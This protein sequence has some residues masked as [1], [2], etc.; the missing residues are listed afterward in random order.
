MQPKFQFPAPV[1]LNYDEFKLLRNLIF[2]LSGINLADHKK[3]LV[4]ARLFKRLRILGL[5]SFREYYEY[6]TVRDHEGLEQFELVNAISTNKTEFFREN[7]HFEFL[8]QIAFPTL[9]S[10]PVI[11]ILCAGCSTGEEPYSMAIAS[12]EHFGRRTASSVFIHACDINTEVLRYARDG[13]YS[14]DLVRYLQRERLHRYFLRGTGGSS[15][16]VKV[17]PELQNLILFQRHNLLD[18]LPYSFKF[19]IVFCRNVVIY[20][21]RNTQE[22]VINHL[23][24]GL[25]PKGY[26]ILGHSESLAF[27][28]LPVRYIQPSVY[29]KH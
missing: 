18:P 7:A 8:K 29:Q 4:R 25:K 17:K 10:N 1:S 28:K 13:V 16:L 22:R 24:N 27:F 3:E 21:D 9:K 11:R 5:N 26:F 19:D 2:D 15:G 6:L 23:L 20:F 12:Y 14:E